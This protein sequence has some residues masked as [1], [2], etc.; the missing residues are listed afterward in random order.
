[1][2]GVLG[3]GR[4][5]TRM[6]ELMDDLDQARHDA[7]K[8]SEAKSHFLANM[9]HEIRTPMNAIIGL[10]ELCLKTSL[11]DR[12]RN[13]VSKIQNA[14]DA[15]LY[16]IN[17]ILDFSKIEAGKLQMEALPFTLEGVFEQ[18]SAI[19]ALRAETQGVE[20]IYRLS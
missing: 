6:R 12:Q 11:N 13:Y 9:S 10:T 15:L 7:L 2:F 16:I 19:L 3:V 18:L 20:L 1:M 8:A 5:I 4:D 14:S 17:D